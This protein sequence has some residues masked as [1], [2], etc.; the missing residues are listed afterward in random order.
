M[1][2]PWASILG[3]YQVNPE[4]F[5][6]FKLPE[7]LDREA[8]LNELLAE[9]AELEVVYMNPDVLKFIIDK[10]SATRYPVWK[11][12]YET[13]QYKYLPL[14]NHNMATMGKDVQNTVT[15]SRDDFILHREDVSNRDRDIDSRYEDS[16][17]GDEKANDK[18]LTKGNDAFN[19]VENVND[20]VVGFNSSDKVLHNSRD[21]TLKSTDDWNTDKTGNDSRD[22]R[23]GEASTNHT[24]D[25]SHDV[26]DRTDM[27]GRLKEDITDDVI[28]RVKNSEGNTGQYSRQMLIQQEREVAE[29]D[30]YNYIIRDFKRR[31][32]IQVW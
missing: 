31:F 13:T 4:I 18:E 32:C 24:D 17:H 29:F 28:D 6:G 16:L 9:L 20:Y 22:W 27:S 21:D 19:S 5:D 26:D 23:K 10:W 12:L 7:E 8:L 14:N 1:E 30:I 15:D 11:H 25:I 2:R 3:M